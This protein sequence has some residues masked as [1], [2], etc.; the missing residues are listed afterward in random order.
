MLSRSRGSGERLR[1]SIATATLYLRWSL[2]AIASQ[3]Q[4]STLCFRSSFSLVHRLIVS[5]AKIELRE[6]TAKFHSKSQRGRSEERPSKRRRRKSEDEE[7]T[8]APLEQLQLDDD[9][10][11]GEERIPSSELVA[12]SLD[13]L[14]YQKLLL[15][16]ATFDNSRYSALCFKNILFF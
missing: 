4:F 16:G 6:E 3:R 9:E 13:I 14:R 11:D 15:E 10:E 1:W 2:A 7:E 5:F 12:A 8:D